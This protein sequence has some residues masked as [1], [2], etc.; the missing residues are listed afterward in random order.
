[1]IAGA[2]L[3]GITGALLAIPV[4]ATVQSVITV[5]GRRYQLVEEFGGVPGESDRERVEAAMRAADPKYSGAGAVP[6]GPIP[7]AEG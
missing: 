3:F 5:Y 4:V 1:M 2:A 7:P 6:R